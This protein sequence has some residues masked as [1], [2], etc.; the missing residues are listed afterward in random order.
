MTKRST[1]SALLSAV[2]ALAICFTALIGTTFAW[3]TD[4]VTSANNIIK[5]GNLDIELKYWN[6]AEYT[7]VTDTTKLFDDA[8]LWEP[9]HTEVAYLEIS[10]VGTLDL[11]Y[12]LN[13]N[14]VNE[15]IGKTASGAD[16]KLSDHL[17]FSVVNKKLEST[18]D[19]YTREGAMAA[20]GNAKGLKTYNS[21]TTAL[22]SGAAAHYVALIIYMPTDVGNEANHNGVNVP[23]IEM[24]VN[25]FA[26]QLTSEEDSFGPDYDADATIES[27]PV[28]I[29]TEDVTAPVTLSAADV[30]VEVPAAV[31]NA[32]PAE[33]TSIALNYTAPQVD[34]TTNTVSFAAVELVDQN[35]NKI[36]L[37]SNTAPIAVTLPAQTAIAADE[38]VVVLH[39]GEIVA[40]TVVKADGSIA[41][42]ANHFCEV[43][44]A[45]VTK[46]ANEAEL[47]TAVANGGS[48]ML[49]GDITVTNTL[50]VKKDV[51]INLNGYNV[52]A[53][54]SQSTMFQSSSDSE[55]SLIITSSKEGAKIN[56][57]GKSV[58][59]G[60]G[61]T[62]FYNVEINVTEIKSSSYTTFNV[63]GDL[64]LG[65]GTV[66]NVEYLGTSLISNNGKQAIVID[67][68]KINVAEFKV[69]GGAMI[70]LAM[71]TTLAL[72][73]T[74]VTVGLNT[75]YTSYF[76]SRADNATIKGCTFNVADANG[77]RYGV[78]FKSDA[79]VGAK[80]AWAGGFGGVATVDELNAAFQN[81]GNYILIADIELNKTITIP[82]GKT[83]AIDLN[84]YTING[85]LSGTGNQDL[86]LVKGNLT[87]KNGA[88]TLTATQNQGWGAMSTIF[89]ITAGGAVTLDK[90]VAENKGGTDMNFVAHLNNWGT[91]TLNVTNST[92][93][94]T[95]IPVRVFNSG[96]DMNNVTIENTILEGKYCYWVHNYTVADFGTAEKAEHQKTLLNVDI[97]D[98]GNTFANTGKAPVLY[99]FTNT[100]YCDANGNIVE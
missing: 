5:A 7:P 89:D 9:G 91:A 34:A 15:I 25:L 2:L 95:Y 81:G 79:N 93:K 1:K 82:A 69:N 59:L 66:V 46:V 70:S 63:Y 14:V 37:S 50:L 41:Y 49:A 24:G 57:G 87:V 92:L 61:S 42:T 62:E 84:G 52:T 68:A 77:E 35:G 10:N 48:I 67:G 45:K 12:Q 43:T 20:A 4:S 38:D 36:D 18:A 90:V 29:P 85:T 88:I 27:T 80:Y 72:N 30:V 33:V 17:V 71:G 44:V 76:I 31:I 47:K 83:V 8:A 11:K 60:Y 32:L 16:I 65:E 100:V 19:L 13:V 40:F 6:G 3:F 23:S 74:E 97:F 22:E 94:A 51:I 28:A 54:M 99:G 53:N 26:T 96:N 58:L 39:D 78:E 75:T 86:F 98:N 64:T 55:P 21:P 73:D 56:A